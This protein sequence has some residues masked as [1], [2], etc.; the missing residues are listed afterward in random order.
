MHAFSE[1]TMDLVEAR[2]MLGAARR[3]RVPWPGSGAS[4]EQIEDTA[5]GQREIEGRIASWQTRVQQSR[6][7]ECEHAHAFRTALQKWLEVWSVGPSGTG[8]RFR[9]SFERSAYSE[10]FTAAAVVDTQMSALMAIA[11]SDARTERLLSSLT[12]LR[13]EADRLQSRYLLLLSNAPSACDDSTTF[14][15]SLQRARDE[16]TELGARGEG[17][18]QA[19]LTEEQLATWRERLDG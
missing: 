10:A 11:P 3:E 14:L 18:A 9:D 19:I 16:M 8:L 17:S 5:R 13:G 4:A 6:Q 15:H 1:D 12:D 2:L 7:R